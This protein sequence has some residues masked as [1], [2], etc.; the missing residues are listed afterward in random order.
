MKVR[1]L[2][3]N[4]ILCILSNNCIACNSLSSW[5]HFLLG[6]DVNGV[7]ISEKLLCN[8][9]R[10][11]VLLVVVLATS[12]IANVLELESLRHRCPEYICGIVISS[13]C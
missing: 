11:L 13:V 3:L 10:L 4:R 6:M 1:F 12:K 2:L 5:K 7:C 9:M 8:P